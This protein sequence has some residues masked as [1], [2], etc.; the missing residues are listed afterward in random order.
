MAATHKPK[1]LDILT[2]DVLS[3]SKVP[4]EFPDECR[5]HLSAVYRWIR[6]G[7]RGKK[8]ASLRIGAKIVT[9]RQAVA[10]FI[11]AIQQDH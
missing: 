6:T 3:L 7:V 11:E 1:S 8:L 4:S 10:R 2:E 9:S 5:P